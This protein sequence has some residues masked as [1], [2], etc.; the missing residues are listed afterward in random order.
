MAVDKEHIYEPGIYFITFTNYKWIPLFRMTESYDLVY[1]W[2]DKLKDFGHSPLGYV[3]MPNH[4]HALIGFVETK[5]SINTIVGNGKRFIAY[6]I[7]ERLKNAGNAQ[8]LKTLADGVTPSDKRKGKLHE[9]YEPSFDI[10]LCRSYKFVQQKLDYM[11]ANPVTKKWM[12]AKN[13]IDYKH[14]SAAFYETG[15][16]GVY[17]VEHVNNWINEK[18]INAYAIGH[19]PNEQ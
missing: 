4:V 8:M 18:W 15:I 17:E 1:N 7:V 10:K 16:Q 3:I 2:F 19:K 12:L 11:H 14:S 9:V 6:D 13:Y 5:K